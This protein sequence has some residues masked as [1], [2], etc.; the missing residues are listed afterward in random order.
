MLAYGGNSSDLFHGAFMQSGAPIPVGNITGGQVRA[1]PLTIAIIGE[2]LRIVF[3]PTDILRLPRKPNRLRKLERYAI[4]S[5]FGPIRSIPGSGEQYAQLLLLPGTFQVYVLRNPRFTRFQ[6]LS[7]AW[8]PRADGVFLPDNPQ[9]LVQQGKV[10]N[11][12]IVSGIPPIHY[13]YT[14]CTPRADRDS[15]RQRR[16]RRHPVLA[17]QQKR[18]H[19]AGVRAVH[20]HRLHPG[21]LAQRARAALVLLPVRPHG[22]VAVQYVGAE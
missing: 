17:L 13:P 3:E 14:P 2:N 15:H 4:V 11:I 21:R 6:A 16:R 20:Q 22:R 18:D 8:S 12:P 10:M 1:Q 19:R 5:T 7:L 9:K